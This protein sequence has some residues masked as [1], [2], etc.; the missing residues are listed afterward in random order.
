MLS[1]L[2][3]PISSSTAVWHVKDMCPPHCLPLGSSSGPGLGLRPNALSLLCRRLDLRG[4]RGRSLLYLLHLFHL[5]LLRYLTHTPQGGS[6][7]QSSSARLLLLPAHCPRN[8]HC[9]V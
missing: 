1:A 2:L 6:R 3:R 8:T 9:G 7:G 5:C 4:R